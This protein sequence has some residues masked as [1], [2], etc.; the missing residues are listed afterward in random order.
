MYFRGE[1]V[2]STTEQ[3]CVSQ[4]NIGDNVRGLKSSRVKLGGAWR[5]FSMGGE[6]EEAGLTWTPPEDTAAIV[7]IPQMRCL[8]VNLCAAANCH[9]SKVVWFINIGVLLFL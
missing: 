2:R 8:W 9:F 4:G 7:I 5:N 6:A 1:S 3:E